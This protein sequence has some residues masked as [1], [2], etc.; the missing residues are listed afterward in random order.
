[1]NFLGFV[2]ISKS[3]ESQFCG[4]KFGIGG[5]SPT[6]NKIT[7]RVQHVQGNRLVWQHLVL[8]SRRIFQEAQLVCNIHIDVCEIIS[9][10]PHFIWGTCSIFFSLPRHAMQ[11]FWQDVQ[12]RLNH[13][14][15][16]LVQ[17][18]YQFIGRGVLK[19]DRLMFLMHL[20]YRM[21]PNHI[22]SKVSIFQ[23]INI[24]NFLRK[25]H[26]VIITTDNCSIEKFVFPFTHGV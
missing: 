19:E 20:V 18:L 26:K 13:L 3:N 2:N 10:I 9:K 5:I 25:V 21:F 12:S 11:L 1:M 15:R 22:T 24:N 6:A 17:N 16:I 23:I 7:R 8:C 4:N 14:Q